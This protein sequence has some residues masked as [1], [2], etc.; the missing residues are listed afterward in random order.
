MKNVEIEDIKAE[1]I[2]RMKSIRKR[3]KELVTGTYVKNYGAIR[4][5]NY[6]ESYNGV[7]NCC[8]GK[9]YPCPLLYNPCAVCSYFV[10]FIA[11]ADPLVEQT[12]VAFLSNKIPPTANTKT[13][14]SCGEKFLVKGNKKFC[15][16]KCKEK[17]RKHYQAQ[18]K[19][20]KRSEQN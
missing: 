4:C 6:N 13:C 10:Q 2:K 20:K 3:V 9:D 1:N 7:H 17:H 14:V 16:E 19:R 11:P 18:W 8:I 15:S 12:I 5:A